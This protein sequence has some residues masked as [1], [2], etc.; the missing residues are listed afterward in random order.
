MC[1]VII[2]CYAKFCIVRISID[3]GDE[4]RIVNKLFFAESLLFSCSI[5]SKMIL[6]ASLLAIFLNRPSLKTNV[7]FENKLTKSRDTRY[8]RSHVDTQ[9]SCGI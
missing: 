9:Y 6:L 3:Y 7:L 2:L 1:G 5:A 8:F 4:E